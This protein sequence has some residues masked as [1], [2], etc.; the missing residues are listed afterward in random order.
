MSA[1]VFIDTCIFIDYFRG[2]DHALCDVVDQLI[3]D[4]RGVCNG[5]VLAEL[6]YGARGER[7]ER[8]IE[9]ALQA[10]T[11]HADTPEI[12]AAAGKIGASMRKRGLT[13][14][15]TDCI[16][17]AQCLAHDLQ[18]ITHDRHFDSIADVFPLKK[19]PIIEC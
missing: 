18:I 5:I 7:E 14:P 2:R 8:I 11:M 6:L 17:A 9:T 13:I 19:V 4:T 10:L 15:L 16:I 12:C 3:M 1:D